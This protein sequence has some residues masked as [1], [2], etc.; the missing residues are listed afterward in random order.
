MFNS[1]QIEIQKTRRNP[2]FWL[3]LGTLT[4]LL[5]IFTLANHFQTSQSSTPVPANLAQ[6]L[7]YG[8]S[9]LNFLGVL[10]YAVSAAVIVA[11]DYPDRSLQ[12]WLTR[13]I[14]RAQL[15]IARL[16]TILIFGLLLVT[17]MVLLTLG[18]VVFAQ[19]IFFGKVVTE[20]LSWGILPVTILRLFWSALPYLSLTLLCAVI[21]RSPLIAAVSTIIYGTVLENLLLRLGDNYPR[22]LQYLP[23]QLVQIVQFNNYTLDRSAPLIAF[24]ANTMTPLHAALVIGLIS[25]I[26]SG[27]ALVIFS[28]QDLGG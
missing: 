10:V 28:R 22:I 25:I 1:L 18:F 2:A 27:I 24:P 11:F 15:L 16:V 13:G 12:L 8:I 4:L 7:L 14:P 21:S 19:W 17:L 3:G 5:G 23:A 26:L 20:N 6:D 9:N